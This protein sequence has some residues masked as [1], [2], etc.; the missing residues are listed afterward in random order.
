MLH[1]DYETQVK[2]VNENKMHSEKCK[3]NFILKVQETQKNTLYGT[4]T[5]M[6]QWFKQILNTNVRATIRCF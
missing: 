2:V 3:D 4:G 1:Q 5:R 6:C